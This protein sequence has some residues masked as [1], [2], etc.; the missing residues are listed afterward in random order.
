VQPESAWERL[1][2]LAR[3]PATSQHVAAALAAW[4]ERLAE[5][6]NRPR[7]W[8]LA[9]DALYRIAERLPT[10]R[11]QLAGLQMLPPK[12][13][14]RHG[15][16]LL[17]LVTAAREVRAPALAIDRQLDDAQKSRVSKL[18]NQVRETAL[19][20]G[21]PASLLAPRADVEAVA[22]LG[23]AAQVPLLS[24]WRRDVAGAALLG[25]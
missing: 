4:R 21:I 17:A 18:L 13:L 14:E 12:T 5:A 11:D 20:L 23:E 2:G 7:K 22:L 1:K 8:I 16:E 15:A 10:D 19:A 6:R 3:L 24:G 9:D 25:S